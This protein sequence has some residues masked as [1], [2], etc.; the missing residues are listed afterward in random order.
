[1]SYTDRMKRP[2]SLI[3][4]GVND[5]SINLFLI[6]FKLIFNNIYVK[7]AFCEPNQSIFNNKTNFILF[8]T[9]LIILINRNMTSSYR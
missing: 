3:I 9:M 1:M 7:I 8:I 2:L 4:I 5:V 6:Y